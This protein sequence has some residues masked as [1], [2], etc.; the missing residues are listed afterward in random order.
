MLE[1][2]Q[3]AFAMPWATVLLWGLYLILVAR[4]RLGNVH[5][6]LLLFGGLIWCA[7]GT[8][9]GAIAGLAIT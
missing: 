3:M 4:T 1:S 5:W 6:A 7:V 9:M 8:I 2:R